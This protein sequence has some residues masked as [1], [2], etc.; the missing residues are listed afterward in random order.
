MYLTECL[1]TKDHKF[2]KEVKG[3]S[4]RWGGDFTDPD[5]IHMDKKRY[6]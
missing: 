4:W 6:R 2:I 5:K 1:L 3:K